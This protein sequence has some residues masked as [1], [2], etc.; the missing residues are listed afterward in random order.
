MESFNQN[1]QEIENQDSRSGV[2]SERSD[3]IRRL[4]I[5]LT[6][7]LSF[8]WGIVS[9]VHHVIITVPYDNDL[10]IYEMHFQGLCD[11]LR[12]PVMLDLTEI[13]DTSIDI[14]SVMF[15]CSSTGSLIGSFFSK[16]RDFMTYRL[17]SSYL[18]K[19]QLDGS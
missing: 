11:A 4:L 3:H 1:S 15:I 6:I 18:V 8:L 14:I 19:F 17:Y 10:S 12:G 2:T 7:N 9:T 13:Y 16:D 5:T